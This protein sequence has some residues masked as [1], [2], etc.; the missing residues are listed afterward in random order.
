M[1][2]C[3]C[4]GH[5]CVGEGVFDL[6]VAHGGFFSLSWQLKTTKRVYNFCAQDVQLAQQWIDRIQSCLSDA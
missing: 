2:V 3:S 6:I 4:G 5:G 1:W